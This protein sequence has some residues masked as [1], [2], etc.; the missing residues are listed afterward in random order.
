MQRRGVFLILGAIG[1][2][3]AIVADGN[4]DRERLYGFSA[5]AICN[6]R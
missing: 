1:G 4:T 6:P 5:A 2:V 3:N